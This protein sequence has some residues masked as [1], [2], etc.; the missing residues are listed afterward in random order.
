M[1]RPSQGQ[2]QTQ[3]KSAPSGG[4]A[5]R[6]EDPLAELA[7][8]IG[9][10]DP[11]KEF[12]ATPRRAPANGNAAPQAAAPRPERRP[13]T[14]GTVARVPVTRPAEVPRQP[15]VSSRP[16]QP[17]P[18]PVPQAAPVM[19]SVDRTEAQPRPVR[20]PVAPVTAP[21]PRAVTPSSYEAYDRAQDPRGISRDTSARSLERTNPRLREEEAVQAYRQPTQEPTARRGYVPEE[22]PSRTRRPAQAYQEP[23]YEPD[24]DPE[25]D[26][27]AYL[28]DHADEIY[29]DVEK[30]RRGIGFWIVGSIVAACLVAV[31]FLGVFAY[32]TIF[33]TPQRA[34]VVT[35]SNAPTKVEPQKNPTA[36]TPASNKPIQDR[37]GGVINETQTLRRE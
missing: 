2:P 25:Y 14:N 11:F 31:A 29:D 23:A 9:Q 8:L 4:R 32:R 15:V 22:V 35:K 12:D 20:A 28:G 24:Y 19:R 5:R 13:V 30:P 27:E 6:G 1:Y 37:I 21:Q 3:A 34:A 18:R 17:A 26:D 33:N 10:E 36:V 16:A 7:R